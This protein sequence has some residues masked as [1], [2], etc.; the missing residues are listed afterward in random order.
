M[1][2][3]YLDYAALTSKLNECEVAIK[4]IDEQVEIL[5]RGGIPEAFYLRWYYS[6]PSLISFLREAKR[7]QERIIW[8]VCGI[9]KPADWHAKMRRRENLLR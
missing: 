4:L 1:A 9:L 5:N 6:R 8:R 2:F 7:D 3:G